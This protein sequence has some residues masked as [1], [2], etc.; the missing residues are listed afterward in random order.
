[1]SFS[2]AVQKCFL[3]KPQ[4]NLRHKYENENVQFENG[5]HKRYHSQCHQITF[6]ILQRGLSELYHIN[7]LYSE[8]YTSIP[9]FYQGF[10]SYLK[11]VKFK[12]ALW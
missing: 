4:N 2:K 10:V 11:L 8:D 12:V 1:M 5:S 7:N 9:P 3:Y 6:D